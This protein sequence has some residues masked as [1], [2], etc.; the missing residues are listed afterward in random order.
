MTQKE[1][2]LKMLRQGPC[3]SRDFLREYMPRFPDVI[4]RLKA[5]GHHIT[6][7]MEGNGKRYT[8]HEKP[9]GE[10]FG[11]GQVMASQSKRKP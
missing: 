11:G 1:R 2:I 8:L 7:V 10:L 5:D 9:Q 3:H 6:G 4:M